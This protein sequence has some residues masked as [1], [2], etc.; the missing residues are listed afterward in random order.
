MGGVG[1]VTFRPSTEPFIFP[2]GTLYV[3]TSLLLM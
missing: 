3:G 1:G 2:P